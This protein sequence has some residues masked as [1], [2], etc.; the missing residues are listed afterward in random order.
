M[1]LPLLESYL[2]WVADPMPPPTRRPADLTSPASVENM[3]PV[4]GSRKLPRRLRPR[5]RRGKQSASSANRNSASRV[6]DPATPL[7]PAA[8]GNSASSTVTRLRST[9]NRNSP[10]PGSQ[11]GTRRPPRSALKKHP[12]TLQP[13]Q[14]P[15]HPRS[16]TNENTERR[17]R[18]DHP[19]IRGIYKPAQHNIRQDTLTSI[20]RDSFSGSGLSS[21]ALQRP[22]QESFSESPSG[23]LNEKS[24]TD[25]RKERIARGKRPGIVYPLQRAARPDT[26]NSFPARSC[27]PTSHGTAS[28][29][30]GHPG[31]KTAGG[32]SLSST[33]STAWIALA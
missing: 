2:N 27:C 4:D 11:P 5:C 6:A 29:S 7:G 33:L 25:S 24:L 12:Q 15:Q 8:N 23:Q 18:L 32:N 17:P 22:H 1:T 21:P 16:T 20:Y 31:A 13:S 19:E 30:G 14:H 28:Y 3:P 9:A 10:I 26:I